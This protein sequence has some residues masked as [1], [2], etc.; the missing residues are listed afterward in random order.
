MGIDVLSYQEIDKLFVDKQY[1]AIEKEYSR[2]LL[3]RH[4]LEQDNYLLAKYYLE[5]TYH[6]IPVDRNYYEIGYYIPDEDATT[7]HGTKPN[8]SFAFSTANQ[9]LKNCSEEARPFFEKVKTDAS[10]ALRDI[11]KKQYN[12]TVKKIIDVYSPYRD[13]LSEKIDKFNPEM[14][15]IELNSTPRTININDAWKG[16][17]DFADLKILCAKYN[18]VQK[19]LHT[20]SIDDPNSNSP[21]LH[22][23]KEC[24][25]LH[26]DNDVGGVIKQDRNWGG[27]KYFD[28][29]VSWLAIIPAIYRASKEGL[30]FFKVEGAKKID[31]ADDL[32]KEAFKPRP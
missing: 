30:G 28:L 3:A 15:T 23:L 5:G 31:A 10:V 25:K 11:D 14:F 16:H 26:A 19:I 18:A 24:A 7:S 29:V 27:W 6:E 9:N 12:G 2:I 20:L 32:L 17:E 4:K 1:D 22:A 13:S 21:K 8:P